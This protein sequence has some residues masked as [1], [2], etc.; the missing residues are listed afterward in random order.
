MDEPL[1]MEIAK[2]GALTRWYCCP[3]CGERFD[4]VVDADPRNE[5]EMGWLWRNVVLPLVL[6]RIDECR[7]SETMFHFGTPQ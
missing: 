4:L 6:E 1:L 2:D 5:R 3:I 7:W